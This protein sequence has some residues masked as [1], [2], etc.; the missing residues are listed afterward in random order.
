MFFTCWTET[1]I[2][3][4]QAGMI[5]SQHRVG[6][7][8]STLNADRIAL[9][10]HLKEFFLP[11]RIP[12]IRNLQAF[13]A[14]GRLGSYKLAALELNLTPSAISHRI[15]ALEDSLAE[16][17]FEPSGRNVALTQTGKRYL[18]SICRVFD[19]LN[20]ATDQIKRGGVGGLF[21]V[22]VFPTL[23]HRWLISRLGGF[24]KQ[25]P[26][27]ELNIQTTTHPLDFSSADT[28]VVIEYAR[29]PIA[30]YECDVIGQDHLMTICSPCYVKANGPIETL[31]DLESHTLIHTQLRENEWADFVRATDVDF[32]HRG[33][34]LRVST[35]DAAIEA[36]ASGLGVA[37]AHA[38]LVNDLLESGRI[39]SPFDCRQA[40]GFHYFLVTTHERAALPR[41]AAFRAWVKAEFNAKPVA[42]N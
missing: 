9:P 20:V 4:F 7:A 12:P 30:D 3:T 38:P 5:T 42:K 25:Y 24:M 15:A 35:R 34:N 26:E 32:L 28:D 2:I 21:T 39:I 11:I 6:S 10:Y 22:R 33:Q 13:E 40:T 17:L 19:Q 31:T 29:E 27:V 36:A 16:R 8:V 1:F 41:V 18:T 14:A 23:A 37:L